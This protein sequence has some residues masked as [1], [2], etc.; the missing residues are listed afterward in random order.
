MGTAPA[1]SNRRFANSPHATLVEGNGGMRKVRIA[2]PEVAGE[3]YLHGAHITSWK[4]AGRDEM[5]FLSTKSRWEKS[6][7]IRGGVPICFPWFGGKADDPKAPAH[8]FARTKE[9]Q[10]ESVAEDD[11]GISVNMFTESDEDTQR[12]WPAEF[13]LEYR[14]H[15]GAELRLELELTNTGKNSLRFEEALHTYH[16]VGNVQNARVGGLDAVDYID[17]AD[18]N[19]KKTQRGDIAIAS[20]TDRIYLNTESAIDLE[21]PA[22]RRRTRVEKENSSTT[23]I[24]NPWVQKA[25]VMPDFADNEWMQM[26]C[27]ETSN[28]ADYA[29]TL[30]PGQLHRM[31]AIVKVANL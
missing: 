2:S 21:D 26:L 10:L 13:H 4:P 15:F 11:N 29:V 25:R 22:M 7:A 23:V 5:L 17:K 24:W 1:E 28:V 6:V 20:E 16:R 14:V 31:A 12:W 3:I 8:G 30:D 18:A 27:I 9:W 19:R